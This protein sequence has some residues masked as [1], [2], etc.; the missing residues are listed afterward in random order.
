MWSERFSTMARRAATPEISW[1]MAQAL[2]VPGLISLAAGFVDQASLPSELVLEEF[3]RIFACAET[4]AAA[5]QYGTT[6]GD[7]GLRA[8]LLERYRADGVLAPGA[9]IDESHCLV[10]SGSQQILYLAA[11]ALLDDGDIVLLEAPTY[12]V[13]LDTLRARSV[14]TIGIDTDEMGMRL[15]RLE[16]SLDRLEA[17]GEL[18]RVK[19]LYLMSYA[20]NP[21]GITLAPERRGALLERLRAYREKGYP[22]LLV[23]DAA[24][25]GLCFETPSPEPIKRDDPE[26]ELVL[27]TES[28]SKSLAPGLRLGVGIGP[29]SVMR[30][31]ADLKG[32]HDFGSTNLNQHLLR[33]LL[34]SGGFD[35]HIETVRAVYR[36]KCDIVQ[37]ILAETFPAET[38]WLRPS[39]GLYTWVTL[40]KAFDTGVEGHVFQ[41]AMK[42]KVL[43]VPGALCYSSDR[44]ESRHCSSL[45]LSYGMI[46]EERLRTGCERLA[47]ALSR[48]F[49]ASPTEL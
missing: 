10:G 9:G 37:S 23:E 18:G 41:S 34:E 42:E 30:K 31:M 4:G 7:L 48:A 44:A 14:R 29:E 3:K 47:R 5:L 49:E 39:G 43:Y 8:K 20:T 17:S 16:E 2:E 19:M 25:R 1:L 15:D 24:Y 45:R 27:Y 33:G 13:F 36:R 21:Q 38:A 40:P 6:Q 22:I 26:N 46:D 35:E 11:E 32:G 12:F 28:F